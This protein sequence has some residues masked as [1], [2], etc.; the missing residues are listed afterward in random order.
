MAARQARGAGRREGQGAAPAVEAQARAEPQV[1][2]GSAAQPRSPAAPRAAVARKLRGSDP[3]DY[4][5][6]PPSVAAE[7]PRPRPSIPPPL[8]V[9]PDPATQER[10]TPPASGPSALRKNRRR[11]RAADATAE[12]AA[13]AEPPTR[14]R[15][16]PT[17]PPSR[18]T[19]QQSHPTPRPSCARRTPSP[20]RSRRARAA[21]KDDELGARP[22]RERPSPAGRLLHAQD[23]RLVRRAVDLAEDLVRAPPGHRPAVGA[24]VWIFDLNLTGPLDTRTSCSESPVQ[25]H[26]TR[27]LRVTVTAGTPLERTK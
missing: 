6:P 16:R 24:R 15:S 1:G 5:G 20:A 14:P 19:P 8:T 26:V 4:T 12:L 13:D 3:A 17:Q 9:A 27:V 2:A 23:H 21:D 18:R 11:R 7:P 22:R 25:R 10:D